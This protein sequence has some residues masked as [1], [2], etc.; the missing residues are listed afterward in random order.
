M[1]NAGNIPPTRL[2]FRLEKT[3][4]AKPDCRGLCSPRCPNARHL[5]RPPSLVVLASPG[6]WATRRGFIDS[7]RQWKSTDAN[8]PVRS[9][10]PIGPLFL[11]FRVVCGQ[12]GSC[13]T[14]HRFNPSARMLHLFLIE[15]VAL[16]DPNQRATRSRFAFLRRGYSDQQNIVTYPARS[17]CCPSASH[18]CPSTGLCRSARR[19]APASPGS[20]GT[21]GSQ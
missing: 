19:A 3:V 16:R 6:T 14:N 11:R 5:G 2:I 18:L 15:R 1:A 7:L 4:R 20:D 12:P 13:T 9:S 21:D 8:I 17:A 10:N